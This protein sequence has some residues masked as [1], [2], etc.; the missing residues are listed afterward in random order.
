MRV[1]L[2][3]VAFMGAAHPGSISKSEVLRLLTQFKLSIGLDSADAQLSALRYAITVECSGAQCFHKIRRSCVYR[4]KVIKSSQI[5]RSRFSAVINY[6]RRP[7]VPLDTRH[8]ENHRFAPSFT[9]PR[10]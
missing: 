4:E 8:E 7:L 1:L 6:S 3:V 10:S 2:V 5:Y 9:A